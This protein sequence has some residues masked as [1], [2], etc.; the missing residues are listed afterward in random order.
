VTSTSGLDPARPPFRVA[1]ASLAGGFVAFFVSGGIAS[2]YGPAAPAFRRV[3]GVEPFVSGLPASV[4]PFLALVGVLLWAALARRVRPG[5]TMAAAAGMLTA[6]AIGVALAPG[7]LSVLAWVVLVGL[8][9]GM[10]SNAMNSIYPRDTG[11]RTPVTVGRMHGAFGVG[12]VAM[13]LVLAA[14]GYVV[15]FLVVA[16]LAVVAVPLLTRTTPPPEVATDVDT[17]PAP[18]VRRAVGGFALL[19]ACYVATES[20]TAA[21][22]ATYLEGLGWSEASA[23]RWTSAFWLVFTASRFVVAPLAQRVAPGRL[24]RSAVPVA[25]VLLLV[26]NVP[27]LAPF[28][29]VG[30]G[31]FVA[32]VFPS[33]MV[34]LARAVPGARHGTTVAMVAA[35]AGATVGPV[36]VG[37]L[38][39]VL[40]RAAIPTGL[41]GLAAATA[42]VARHLDV[43]ADAGRRRAGSLAGAA[44][45]AVDRAVDRAADRAAA[46]EAG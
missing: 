32:P 5:R 10:L 28:A 9:F 18:A 6:G 34:W 17:A 44:D 42:L 33:A 7:M 35:T 8:G 24:V 37:G 1:R 36:L 27:R 15:A 2:L 11:S 26:A 23:A 43:R 25:V 38:S 31:L 19:F 30:A 4:H 13:P 39:T 21:W 20:A 12:A 45:R 3:F 14:Q 40:G 29:L 46:P 16:V 41:A 22:L